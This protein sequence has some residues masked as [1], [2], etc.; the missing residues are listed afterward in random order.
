[1]QNL[2]YGDLK[3]TLYEKS[4]MIEGTE[5]KRL[6]LGRPPESE[7]IEFLYA[8]YQHG[9]NKKRQEIQ[10]VLSRDEPKDL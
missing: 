10:K 2:F 1:M 8:L 6:F 7:D 5:G 4:I 3:F 9:R